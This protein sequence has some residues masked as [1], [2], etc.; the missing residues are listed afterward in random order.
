[1]GLLMTPGIIIPDT[2]EGALPGDPIIRFYVQWVAEQSRKGGY[3]SGEE[4]EEYWSNPVT[5]GDGP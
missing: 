5:E 2:R 4:W 1:M 3:A